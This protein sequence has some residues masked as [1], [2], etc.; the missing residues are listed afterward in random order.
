MPKRSSRTVLRELADIPGLRRALAVTRRF[1]GP[2][3]S[4]CGLGAQRASFPF[5]VCPA[6]P[7]HTGEPCCPLLQPK[8]ARPGPKAHRY[9]T[10]LGRHS[11]PQPSAAR[12]TASANYRVPLPASRD[13]HAQPSPVRFLLVSLHDTQPCSR[14]TRRNRGQE[15]RACALK[16]TSSDGHSFSCRALLTPRLSYG[17][18]RSTRPD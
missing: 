8:L 9:H 12:R 13:T 16:H 3:A 14:T 1:A 15:A 4:S 17:L 6:I 10:N 5:R 11:Y 7:A 2:V 18:S